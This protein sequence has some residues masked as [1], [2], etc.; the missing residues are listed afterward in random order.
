MT[1]EEHQ[2]ETRIANLGL[3][4]PRITPQRIDALMQAVTYSTHHVPGT[5]TV[6]AT[7]LMPSGFSLVTAESACASPENFN[8]T[9]GIEIAIA[10]AE[11]LARDELWKLEGYRLK[12]TLHELKQD[13]GNAAIAQAREALSASPVDPAPAPCCIGAACTGACGSSPRG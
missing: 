8:V 12:Q 5:T 9:L 6:L 3:N 7:A 4:A 1:P 11:R 13:I 10:K 2:I